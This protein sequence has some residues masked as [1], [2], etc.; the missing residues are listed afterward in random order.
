MVNTAYTYVTP[1]L[2]GITIGVSVYFG[3]V[4]GF[5]V[6]AIIGCLLMSFCD[7]FKCRYLIYFACVILF[8]AALIGFLLSTIFSIM[9]PALY[10]SCEFVDYS[11]SSPANFKESFGSMLDLQKLAMITTCFPGQTGDLLSI[12]APSIAS[13]LNAALSS[14]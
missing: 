10:Y 13:T 14:I 7:K 3:V 1:A 8:L 11:F 9:T 5:T 6:L 4:I 12:L 2:D